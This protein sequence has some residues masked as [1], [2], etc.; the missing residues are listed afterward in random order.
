MKLVYLPSRLALENGLYPKQLRTDAVYKTNVLVY[1]VCSCTR[2]AKGFIINRMLETPSSQIFNFFIP[3][4]LQPTH[5][6]STTLH[7]HYPTYLS[8]EC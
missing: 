8:G 3:L 4:L 6:S 5:Y 2:L 1:Q 7:A